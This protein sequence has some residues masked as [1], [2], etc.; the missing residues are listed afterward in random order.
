MLQQKPQSFQCAK[1]DNGENDT[2]QF[3]VQVTSNYITFGSVML[4]IVV[5]SIEYQFWWNR[6]IAVWK[7]NWNLKA[8]ACPNF[9]N[10]SSCPSFQCGF[11]GTTLRTTFWRLKL[12]PKRIF[13]KNNFTQEFWYFGQLTNPPPF[14]ELIEKLHDCKQSRLHSW[15]Q[16]P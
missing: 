4:S 16:W 5:L 15:G 7:L 10:R 6:S 11:W 12:Y 1:S 9:D 13:Y 2:K 8:P 3:I 14:Q